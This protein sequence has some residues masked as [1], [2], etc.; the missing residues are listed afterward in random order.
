LLYPP[1]L[2]ELL[3]PVAGRRQ[4]GRAVPCTGCGWSA[5]V[6]VVGVRSLTDGCLESIYY[7]VKNKNVQRT[8]RLYGDRRLTPDSRRY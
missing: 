8:I 6:M 7:T 2:E 3:F 1:H 5:G 4:A